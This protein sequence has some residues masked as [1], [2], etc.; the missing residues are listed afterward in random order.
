M[1]PTSLLNLELADHSLRR[2]TE[3]GG[4]LRCSGRITR[5][6]VSDNVRHHLLYSM[7]HE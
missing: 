6:V 3:F 5:H 7:S 1:H 4:A 2:L